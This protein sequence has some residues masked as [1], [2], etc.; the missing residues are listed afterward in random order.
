M[1]DGDDSKQQCLR[2]VRALGREQSG[3]RRRDATLRARYQGPKRPGPGRPPT[4]DGP[5]SW[6]NL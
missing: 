2:G 4:S 6:A 1:T 3:T 5:V